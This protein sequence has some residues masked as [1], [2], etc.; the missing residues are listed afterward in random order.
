MEQRINM[1]IDLTSP[2]ETS[3]AEKW[4]PLGDG[5]RV[6]ASIIVH[7]GNALRD[8]IRIKTTPGV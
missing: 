8:G 6:D 7:P 1:V 4:Q 2:A 5:Y 3:P